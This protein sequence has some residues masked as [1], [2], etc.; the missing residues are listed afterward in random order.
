MEL[1]QPDSNR[2]NFNPADKTSPSLHMPL[3]EAGK[4]RLEDA[5]IRAILNG[6]SPYGH[7]PQVQN[8]GPIT[9]IWA[10]TSFNKGGENCHNVVVSMEG[11]VEISGRAMLKTMDGEEDVQY[12]MSRLRDDERWQKLGKLHFA[13]EDP[14]RKSPWVLRAFLDDGKAIFFQQKGFAMNYRISEDVDE[15]ESMN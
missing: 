14:E 7:I 15:V 5:G 3:N 9:T 6:H 10:D 1:Q 8:D 11:D 4:V 13:P 2:G 12:S